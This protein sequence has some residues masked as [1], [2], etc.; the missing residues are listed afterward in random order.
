MTR[1]LIGPSTIRDNHEMMNDLTKNTNAQ[2]ADETVA[3]ALK[4]EEYYCGLVE[5]GKQINA[6]TDEIWQEEYPNPEK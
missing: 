2:P 5:N 6:L 4:V 3:L 1:N